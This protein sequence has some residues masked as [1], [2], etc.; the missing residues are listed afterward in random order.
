[1]PP[2]PEDHTFTAFEHLLSPPSTISH[3]ISSFSCIPET[4]HKFMYKQRDYFYLHFSRA[5]LSPAS[6]CLK[7]I[8][9]KTDHKAV[10]RRHPVLQHYKYL[11]PKAAFRDKNVGHNWQDPNEKHNQFLSKGRKPLL[12][13]SIQ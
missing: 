1:M 7:V 6:P 5:I 4:W 2:V 9:F 3:S 10:K 12:D 11:T 8:W 13:S